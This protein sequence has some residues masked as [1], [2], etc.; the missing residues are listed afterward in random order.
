MKLRK[1]IP[2]G[3]DLVYIGRVVGCRGY[4]SA[5]ANPNKIGAHG[6]RVIAFC[7]QHVQDSEIKKEIRGLQIKLQNPSLSLLVVRSLP[8]RRAL[9]LV[10]G[11]PWREAEEAQSL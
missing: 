6:S 8:R 4:R 5:W 10:G 7:R 1:E 11:G 2:L 9:G 3:K